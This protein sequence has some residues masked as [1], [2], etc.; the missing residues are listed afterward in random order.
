VTATAFK[1]EAAD[2]TFSRNTFGILYV[3]MCWAAQRPSVPV[4]TPSKRGAGVF[5]LVPPDVPHTFC[6][7]GTAPARFLNIRTPAGLEQCPK[8]AAAE[9]RD[10]TPNPWRIAD[11]AAQYAF[12]VAD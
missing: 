1:A 12:V 3:S 2:A 4:T 7:I 6:K 10:G 5:A 8:D 9:S 11:V